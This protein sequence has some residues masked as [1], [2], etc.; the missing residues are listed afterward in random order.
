[1]LFKEHRGCVGW[2]GGHTASLG[3]ARVQSMAGRKSSPWQLGREH[4]AFVSGRRLAASHFFCANSSSRL[5]VF[6]GTSSNFAKKKKAM[7]PN[8]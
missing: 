3:H 8:F 6:W 7:F 1:M 4:A 2:G 5:D